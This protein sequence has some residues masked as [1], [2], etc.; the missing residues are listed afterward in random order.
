[1]SPPGS[2]PSCS[3]TRRT[4]PTRGSADSSLR[5]LGTPFFPLVQS[6]LE[7]FRADLMDEVPDLEFGLAKKLSI[8]FGG[9]Q[10]GDRAKVVADGLHQAA[11]DAL[12]L[13]LLLGCEREAGHGVPPCV[14]RCRENRPTYQH[15][16][17]YEISHPLSRRLPF[18]GREPSSPFTAPCA[19]WHDGGP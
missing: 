7:G 14:Q 6:G 13:V 18:P 4:G 9:E 19:L 11:L 3:G 1:M 5:T 17:L 12:R 15:P 8:G 10:L 2:A 16:L